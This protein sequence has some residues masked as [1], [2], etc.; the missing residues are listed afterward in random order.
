M[1][2]VLE[3]AL[4]SWRS[5]NPNVAES[6]ADERTKNP[7]AQALVCTIAGLGLLLLGFLLDGQVARILTLRSSNIWRSLAIYSS[8]AGEG[9]VI[10]V[11]G[12]T[13]SLLLLLLRRF[14]ASRAVFL[15]ALTGLLTGFAATI[16]R[17]LLGRTRPDSHEIQGFYGV[18]HHA[19]W[20]FGKYEFGAF[21]SGHA[22]TVI[23]LATA[24]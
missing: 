3:H 1:L 8:K 16:M 20:I 14:R 17:S 22:A 5:A 11:V 6:A 13:I 15:V 12:A 18:W 10:A 9:W 2:K 7:L 19:H 24:A 23:G 4:A 21:P